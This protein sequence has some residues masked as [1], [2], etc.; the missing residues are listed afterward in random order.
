[1]G[2]ESIEFKAIVESNWR[3][4][5]PA[6]ISYFHNLNR[7]DYIEVT[8]GGD[9]DYESFVAK[10]YHDLRFR[11]PRIV[12]SILELERGSLVEVEIDR[13]LGPRKPPHEKPQL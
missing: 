1:M 3:V 8:L 11:V 10:I 2:Q 4:K 7:G 5:I 12:R 13:N 9:Y 6:V